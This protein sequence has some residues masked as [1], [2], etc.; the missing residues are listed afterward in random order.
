[1]TPTDAYYFLMRRQFEAAWAARVGSLPGIRAPE[2]EQMYSSPGS[3]T[4]IISTSRAI[5]NILE[6]AKNTPFSLKNIFNR[7]EFVTIEIGVH[8]Q[9]NLKYSDVEMKSNF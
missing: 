5:Y 6:T 8:P 3:K 7:K 4:T 2:T 9:K 1:M